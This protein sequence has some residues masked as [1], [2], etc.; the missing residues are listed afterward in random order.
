MEKEESKLSKADQAIID[1][2]DLIWK[3]NGYGPKDKK[4]I[5]YKKQDGKLVP[6]GGE[7]EDDKEEP[8]EEQPK[9]SGMSTDDY[10]AN[11]LTS[12]PDADDGEEDG[13][14]KEEKSDVRKKNPAAGKCT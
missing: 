14:G 12:E 2:E 8:E 4:G 3:R 13:E 5:T 1:K 9:A 6:I 10:A 11:A 7:K